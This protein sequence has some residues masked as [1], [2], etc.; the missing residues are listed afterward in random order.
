MKKNINW[1]RC[2]LEILIII[3]YYHSNMF[4]YKKEFHDEL[5]F[6][7]EFY[8]KVKKYKIKF[9]LNSTQLFNIKPSYMFKFFYIK[10]EKYVLI[11]RDP[12][13]RYCYNNLVCPICHKKFKTE[14]Y[15]Y[16]YHI[17]SK[18]INY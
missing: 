3:D 7:G 13:S 15:F 10:S 12:R 9:R 2:P 8:E 17:H 6:F 5:L 4:G 16:R 11:F 18:Y 14:R 1:K